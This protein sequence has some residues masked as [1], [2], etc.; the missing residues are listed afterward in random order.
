M[1]AVAGRLGNNNKKHIG[2]DCSQ[3]HSVVHV[4]LRVGHR[5]DKAF[6]NVLV[7]LW[8]PR[9][10]DS[11]EV[12]LFIDRQPLASPKITRH[13]KEGG[14]CKGGNR[15]DEGW[16]FPLIGKYIQIQVP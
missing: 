8:R 7:E 4:R 3:S 2:I 13:P 15:N 14:W 5:R 1:N 10:T 9:V 6:Q 16:G 11:Q 12:A